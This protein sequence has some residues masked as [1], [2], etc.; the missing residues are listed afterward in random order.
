M[1]TSATTSS[2]ARDSTRPVGLCGVLS[3]SIRVR[4]PTAA[5]SSSGSS[6]NSG[7]RSVTGRRTAPANV[8]VAGYES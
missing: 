2:S 6:V 7:G 1:Q 4:G 3:S 5:R 8:I